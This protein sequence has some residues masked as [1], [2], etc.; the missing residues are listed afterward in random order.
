[1]LERTPE[2]WDAQAATFDEQPDHGLRDPAV[3]A[4]WAGVL[5]PLLPVAPS[6]V[7]DLGCGTGSLAV[8]LAG[9][10]HGVLGVDLSA[11]M[12]AAAEAKA[13]SAGVPA[14][15]RRG[16]ASHPPVPPASCDVVLARHVVWALP[17]PA[18]TVGRWVRLLRPG[19]LL[20]LVEGRWKTGGG[21]TAA[22]CQSLVLGHRRHAAVRPLPDPA[23]WGGPIEDERYLVLSAS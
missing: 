14:E 3:R 7:V 8:L 17:D 12:V 15:F 16:D 11:G 6:S 22:E 5:L 2:F 19:G 21:L 18:A 4:A 23:L 1:M 13:R 10:G 9:A 20:V